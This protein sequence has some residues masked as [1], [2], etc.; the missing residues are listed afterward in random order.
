MR[1]LTL[2]FVLAI[3]GTALAQPQLQMSQEQLLAAE[4]G[5]LLVLDVR[6]ELEYDRGF[7]PGALHIPQHDLANR[8]EELKEWRNKSVVVYC[9]TGHRADIAASLLTEE[10]FSNVYHLVGDMREWR[11]SGREIAF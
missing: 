4:G 5:N 11:N 1:L 10:G 3:S 8:L 2:L 6:S 9:E 7:I